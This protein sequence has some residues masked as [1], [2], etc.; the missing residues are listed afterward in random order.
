MNIKRALEKLNEI[1]GKKVEG[2][3]HEV[4]LWDMECLL[5]SFAEPEE[6]ESVFDNQNV[7][8]VC[9][10]CGSKWYR[11]QFQ[12]KKDPI[13]EVYEKYN[14]PGNVIGDIKSIHDIWQAIKQ[15]C[16]G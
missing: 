5:M 2:Y 15:H 9:K 3:N 12:Y 11:T 10:L 16:E 8:G 7:L 6:K 14:K 4:N 1:K 13:K